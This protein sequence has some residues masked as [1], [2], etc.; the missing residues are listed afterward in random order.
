MVT[1]GLVNELAFLSELKRGKV[2]VVFDPDKTAHRPL[3]L[4]INQN[5]LTAFY[6]TELIWQELVGCP[7]SM[8]GIESCQHI[9]LIMNNIDQNAE[10]KHLRYIEEP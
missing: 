3:K 10:W 1:V 7:E 5:R 8:F 6:G 9:L 4:V 2:S